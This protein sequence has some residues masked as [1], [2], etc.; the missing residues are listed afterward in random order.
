MIEEFID[1]F[2]SEALEYISVLEANM[3]QLE[4]D[5]N[6][7]VLVEEIFRVM[8]NLKGNSSMFGFFNIDNIAHSLE[9]LFD[10]V[11]NGKITIDSYFV[12]TILEIGDFLRVLINSNDEISQ[13]SK[14]T[15]NR[16]ISKIEE[17]MSS[18]NHYNVSVD[19]KMLSEIDK[20]NSLYYIFVDF[21]SLI[22]RDG[23]NPMSFIDDVC[24]FG[25]SWIHPVTQ[26]FPSLIEL[27][28]KLNNQSWEIILFTNK[29]KSEIANVFLSIEDM[30]NVE[31][32]KISDV[33][34]LNDKSILNKLNSECNIPYKLGISKICDLLSLEGP[35]VN[36][37]ATNEIVDSQINSIR[38]ASS[39][40]DE[41][42][43]I[44]SEQVIVQERLKMLSKKILDDELSSI[45]DG[46]DKLTNKLRNVAFALI[47]IPIKSLFPRY[48]RM[49]RDVAKELGKD[50][51]FDISDNNTELDKYVVECLSDPLMHL[52]RNSLD[53]AI[54]KASERLLK[55]KSEKGK[56]T[57][58]SYY[59]GA[60]VIIE[61]SDDGRGI[62]VNMVKE[63]AIREGLL[64]KDDNIP[65]N[66]VINFI[67][68]PG[69][70]TATNVSDISGR[71][72]GLDVVFKNILNLRGTI[73]VD[74]CQDKGTTF[75]IKLPITLSIFDGLII[76]ANGNK[77][78]VP[79]FS[80]QKI[81]PIEYI[82]II[83]NTTKSVVINKKRIPFVNLIEVF[84]GERNDDINMA[85]MLIVE[86]D[87][88]EF[89][90]IIDEVLGEYQTVLKSINSFVNVQDVFLG[91][92][93]LGDGKT[94]LV[95]DVNSLVK[96]RFGLEMFTN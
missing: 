85:N 36:K 70:S 1:K 13:E 86:I 7:A 33:D 73:S 15:K 83:N 93:I 89:G 65:D 6:D 40:L 48:Q 14:L 32:V 26:R 82:D 58:K 56:I 42:I 53:H 74:T 91:A 2:K 80:V 52:I 10:K 63:K 44:V 20:Q 16:F 76:K 31:I 24:C 35:Y 96:A 12:T 41:L 34:L 90:I 84:E 67:F 8:H 79:L 11:R 87:G 51:V 45:T 38:V 72:V 49:I 81:L 62:D 46:I 4:Q 59:S 30:V 22:L 3:L 66:Q 71:G 17:I 75:T 28:T 88:R 5:P 37:C 55:S 50:I 9:S 68:S 21:K 64:N 92:S 25:N 95:I 61:V 78:I 18:E 43:N 77:Y 27:N 29:R 39:K 19:S 94:V 23:I 47:L 60:H 69:F 54:E 57:I